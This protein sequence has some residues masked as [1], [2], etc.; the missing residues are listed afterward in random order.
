MP[1]IGITQQL[2]THPQVGL[3]L[4]YRLL[5][6]NAIAP[7]IDF[8]SQL[9]IGREGGL[10]FLNRGIRSGYTAP[11]GVPVNAHRM[12]KDGFQPLRANT[13]SKL[14]QIAWI[15]REAVL[16]M[17][18]PAEVLHVGVAHPGFGQEGFVPDIVESLYQLVIHVDK[19]GQ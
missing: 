18:L 5:A 17:S 14:N 6:H 13:L 8:F 15:T 10:V 12:G 2:F 3:A 19:V 11:G 4:G 9:R 7:V 1:K 16:E